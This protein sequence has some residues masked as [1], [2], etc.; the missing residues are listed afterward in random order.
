MKTSFFQ[1]QDARLAYWKFGFGERRLVFLH[2]LCGMKTHWSEQIEFFGDNWEVYAVDLLGHGESSAVNPENFVSDNAGVLEQFLLS[3]P[4][5]PTVVCGHSLGGLV[6][7]ELLHTP[8]ALAGAVFIDSPCIHSNANR[9]SYADS[10]HDIR[11]AADPSA[12]IT[13]WFDGLLTPECPEPVRRLIVDGARLFPPEWV[14]GILE[15]L[16]LSRANE[17]VNAAHLLV[18]DGAEFIPPGSELSWLRLYPQA[19]DRRYPGPG[20]YFFLEDAEAF[21]R[22]LR[23]FLEAI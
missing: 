12:K 5:A 2:G 3:L 7:G 14:A 21:N 23:L 18:F 19:T 16:P 4:T 1:Y 11:A 22:G 10:G 8:L 15:H 9:L 20:H 17:N 13:D 6:L